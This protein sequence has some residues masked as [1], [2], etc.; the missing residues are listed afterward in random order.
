MAQPTRNPF[1]LWK[2][3]RKAVNIQPSGGDS[4][5]LL[6]AFT[7]EEIDR[8]FRLRSAVARG[9]CTEATPEYKRLVFARWLVQEGRLAD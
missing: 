5:D 2:G 3:K 4:T 7:P 1:E 9:R 8:L 6:A